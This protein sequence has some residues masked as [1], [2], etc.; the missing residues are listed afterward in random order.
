MERG[1]KVILTYL[2]SFVI[3]ILFSWNLAV[4]CGGAVLLGTISIFLFKGEESYTFYQNG[5][6]QTYVNN[7]P[8]TSPS[9]YQDPR[10]QRRGKRVKDRQR[11]QSSL[12]NIPANDYGYRAVRKTSV[13]ELRRG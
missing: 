8:L 12:Y 2:I 7:V 5:T 6:M 13:R 4:A 9:D 3:I 10:L 1:T 11:H